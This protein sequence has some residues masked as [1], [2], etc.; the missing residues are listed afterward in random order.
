[1]A[2]S[3]QEFR[4]KIHLIISV[5]VI[6]PTAL[7]YGFQPESQFDIQLNTIDEHNVFKAIMGIYLGFTVLWL[8]G[9]F[10]IHYLK[11]ALVSNT[12][13]MLSLAFG[14][15]VSYILDGIPTFG[16]QFGL[17][18]ELTLGFYGL[19]VLTNQNSKKYF[20]KLKK[21]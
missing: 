10:K 7:I 3:K 14:R 12:V 13:F 9:I 15:I 20:D 17:L 4:T 16:F 11:I 18:V 8:L 21:A 6:I 19:W 2:Y 5:W 1:M